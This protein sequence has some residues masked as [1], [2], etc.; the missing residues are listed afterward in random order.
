MNVG[1]NHTEPVGVNEILNIGAA[2]EVT[3]GGVRTEQF[4]GKHLENMNYKI[5][6]SQPAETAGSTWNDVLIVPDEHPRGPSDHRM[7]QIDPPSLQMTGSASDA[8]GE[9]LS[10]KLLLAIGDDVEAESP[11]H[12]SSQVDDSLEQYAQT[13]QCPAASNSPPTVDG[14]AQ[15]NSPPLTL[16]GEQASDDFGYLDRKSQRHREW[17][18]AHLCRSAGRQFGA[19]SGQSERAGLATGK[20]SAASS[21]FPQFVS[22]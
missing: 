20:P 3:V 1:L 4:N 5:C 21:N 13:F 8:A 22:V 6:S 14:M 7:T 2:Q 9:S 10:G 12:F 19:A 17:W 15:T 18:P 16:P 11:S